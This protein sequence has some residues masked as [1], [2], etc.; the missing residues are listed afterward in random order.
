VHKKTAIVTG[1]AGFI[2]SH[3]CRML[4]QE[5]YFVVGIDNLSCGFLEN[6]LDYRDNK[7]FRF[8]QD[9]IR[10]DLVEL[11]REVQ[12]KEVDFVFHAAA[13][14]ELY[15]CRDFPSAAVANNIT[16]TLNIIALAKSLNCK[17]FLFTDTSA[18]YDSVPTSSA[19][20]PTNESMSPGLFPPRGIYSITKMCASQFVRASG[21]PYTIVRYFNVY[22]PS[23]NVKR[24]IPPVIGG[25]SNKMLNNEA[26]I[27]Y[28]D[29]SKRRDFIFIDDV[30]ELH[31]RMIQEYPTNNTYNIGTGEN[32]SIYEIYELVSSEIFAN[33]EDWITPIYEEDQDWATQIT[34]SDSS[35]ARRTFKWNCTHTI[36][37]GIAKTVESMR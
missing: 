11:K 36:E 31:R 22:G 6:M 25:F 32:Y 17:H 3:V 24:D 21:L 10:W 19:N 27:I 16:G 7:N 18:E 4:L 35:R 13:R 20:Y 15:W 9:D 12:I 34:L 28:G 26:P 14:G 2:G 5:D 37:D 33:R 29:G 1:C 23:I 30:V 8:C